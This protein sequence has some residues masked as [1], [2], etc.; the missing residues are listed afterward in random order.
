MAKKTTS[1]GGP[2]PP[3]PLPAAHRQILSFY[4][5]F[6]RCRVSWLGREARNFVRRRIRRSTASPPMMM[7]MDLT[8]GRLLSTIESHHQATSREARFVFRGLTQKQS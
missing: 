6:R 7:V 3:Q 8:M 1:G 4:G 2:N 5:Q